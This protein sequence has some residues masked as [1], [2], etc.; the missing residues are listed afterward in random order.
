MQAKYDKTPLTDTEQKSVNGGV[1]V[2]IAPTK[3]VIESISPI[4][5][6]PRYFTQAIGEDGNPLHNYF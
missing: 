1:G 2:D 5:S 6:E 4:P 3:I